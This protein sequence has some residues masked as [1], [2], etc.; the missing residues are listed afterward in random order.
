[1]IK[2]ENLYELPV[3][4]INRYKISV[5]PS[6]LH[7]QTPMHWMSFETMVMQG[8]WYDPS[9]NMMDIGTNTYQRL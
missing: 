1:M 8:T 6:T 2:G 4:T 5:L 3:Y 9:N 7:K